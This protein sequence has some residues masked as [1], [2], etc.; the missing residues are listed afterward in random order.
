MRSVCRLSVL[1]LLTAPL[2]LGDIVNLGI[3]SYDVLIP[4]GSTVPGVNQFSIANLTGDPSA[5]GFG[6]APDFPV[7]DAVTL[8]NARLVLAGPTPYTI[9]LGDLAPGNWPPVSLQFASTEKFTSATLTATLDRNT[10]ALFDSST[11]VPGSLNVNAVLTPASGSSLEAG[12]DLVVF[13]VEDGSQPTVVPE[14]SAAVLFC[15]LL[16]A[17]V[18]LRRRFV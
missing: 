2:L 4:A 14:P 13:S 7:W 1:L 9:D 10:L 15:G 6:S 11:F 16:G 3:L 18:V 12:T 17:L 8:L 5:S